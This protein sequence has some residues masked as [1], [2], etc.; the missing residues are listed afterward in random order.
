M[1]KYLLH[2]LFEGNYRVSQTYG[3]NK[4]YY[5]RFGL[6][7]HEGVDWATPVGVKAL[8]PFNGQILRGGWDKAYGNYIVVWDPK[9]LCAVWFCHLSSIG[10]KGGQKVVV[11]QTIGKTGNT[12]NSSGPH[13]HIGF[14]ETDGYANRLNKWNGYQGF[15]NI[16]DPKLVSWKL[17]R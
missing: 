13:L 7:G 15:L 12:G 9:Q 17:S 10:V 14:V 5:K 11:G 4:L 1:A 16:L 3:A 2:D 6:W 8:A